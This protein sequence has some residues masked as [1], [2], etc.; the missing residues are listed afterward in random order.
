MTPGFYRLVVA[1]F[2][3]GLADHALLI[4][5]LAFLY[6]QGYALWW[7][8][9]LKL[10]FTW[11]YVILA[12]IVGEVADA[13][14]K[15]KL[16]LW[17]QV[18]KSAGVAGFVLGLHPLVAF[19]LV[20]AGAACY[21]PAKYGWVTEQV[22]PHELV[23]ANGWLEVAMVSAVL[24]GTAG[25]GWL[26]SGFFDVNLPAWL[27]KVTTESRL[28]LPFALLILAYA[29]SGWITL[30]VPSAGAKKA[31]LTIQPVVILR[32]FALANVTLWRDALGGLS[33]SATTIFWGAGVVMQLA[34]LQW[35]T[36]VVNLKLE[37]AAYMQ[38]LVAVGIIVGAMWVSRAVP[39]HKAMSLWPMGVLLGLILPVAALIESWPW[40]V[41]MMLAVGA[42]GGALVVPMNALLQYRGYKLLRPGLS[43]AVQ[44]FSENAS[45]LVML[46]IY[47]AVLSAGVPI[48]VIMS[49]FGLILA[50]MMSLLG[51][52]AISVRSRELRARSK[53][54]AKAVPFGQ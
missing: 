18:L 24:L 48:V 20:G 41:P 39:L 27:Q 50:F 19:A 30:Y 7:A 23:K 42:I 38:A 40:A 5:A 25:G 46:A 15:Q 45:I 4:V 26:I 54:D 51:W 53:A 2:T 33:L 52:R 11:S 32:E 49:A 1:Q 21:A 44:G 34:V 36:E 37:Q 8:P 13:F 47:S 28:I 14:P 12:P 17:T 22:K 10:A 31:L 35:A 6:E 16:M 43:I 9:L 3:S 29:A